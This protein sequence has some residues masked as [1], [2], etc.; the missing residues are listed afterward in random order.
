MCVCVREREREREKSARER[1]RE[2]ER[3][4]LEQHV[5]TRNNIITAS[6]HSHDPSMALSSPCPKRSQPSPHPLP[7]LSSA[8]P[9]P[10]PTLTKK[11][12]ESHTPF[13]PYV[14]PHSPHISRQVG[15]AGLTVLCEA[16]RLAGC[17]R[18]ETPCPAAHAGWRRKLYI[19]ARHLGDTA[20]HALAEQVPHPY[21]RGPCI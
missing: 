8:Y 16:A 10:P 7:A 6:W 19:N 15:V 17:G 1:E 4:R 11:Q 21:T 13:P 5:E 20:C 3:E 2:R 9:I 18:R 14:T 12:S